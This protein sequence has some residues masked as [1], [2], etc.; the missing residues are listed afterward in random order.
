MGSSDDSGV[1]RRDLL[2]WSALGAGAAPVAAFIASCASDP[3]RELTAPTSTSPTISPTTSTT[4]TAPTVAPPIAPPI[5]AAPDSTA[6]AVTGTTVAVDPDRPWW[7]QGNYAPVFDE[8][9]STALVVT[10][11]IPPELTG[12]YVRNGSN[13]SVGD[14][15][16]WFFGDGMLHGVR[17]ER[18]R[19]VEYRNRYVQTTMY[20]AGAGFGQGPPGG[21]SNQSN[22]S[23]IW[24][25]DR[26][27]TSGEV[28]LPYR[29]DP[30][31]LA[32]IGP[33]DFAGRLTTA[34]TA[35]PKI[36]PATGRLHS[37]GYG[38]TP[39]YLTYH[40][41]E[42]DGT[43]VHSEVVDVP[44]STMMHDF[45]ITATDAVFWDLP[46]TFD[47]DAAIAY[48]AHPGSAAFPYRW[49]PED[50][51]R[52][53]I[54]PLEG[55]ASAIQWFDLDPCYV[56]HGVNAFRRGDEVVADVCRLS[57]M[58]APGQFLGGEASHRRWTFN[59]ATGATQDDVLAVDNPG[60]LPSRDPRRLGREHRYSYLVGTRENPATV[61]F[62]GLIKHDYR[63]N[64][65][66]EWDPGPSRHAGEWLF[67]PAGSD[68]DD[69]A[70][71]LLGMVHDEA[72]GVSDLV[73]IDASDVTA[74]PV[75]S[76]ALPRRVPY[77]FHAAWVPA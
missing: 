11:S 42:S 38:F 16:H 5:V 4:A 57:S 56:F 49:S 74:G 59:T 55:G 44:R 22:V 60:D 75:A 12:M 13:P 1:S 72:T 77:G 76:I 9:D 27:L 3:G 30:A 73:V 64:S 62:G 21:A 10:G 54:M 67:V 48:I 34:F 33:Y 23:C 58:F 15:P 40:I 71:Y 24:H 52:V 53:G 66:T 63:D 51:S 43:L 36:D 47:L 41:T 37:F 61:E 19:A 20:Q 7:M 45:A 14:S 29:I 18:G 2:R 69:D 26:L 50:G 28:G 65:R 31:T 6:P 70:G 32:T 46:V 68:L 39:P 35:H 17:L 25:A 8:I